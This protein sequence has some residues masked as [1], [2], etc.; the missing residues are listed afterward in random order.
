MQLNNCVPKFPGLAWRLLQNA[1]PPEPEGQVSPLQILT[2]KIVP[3]KPCTTANS[4]VPK[5][6]VGRIKPE[7]KILRKQ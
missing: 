1:G 7:A 2:K 5:R 3:S 6:R 4:G